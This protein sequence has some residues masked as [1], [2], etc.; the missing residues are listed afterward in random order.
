MFPPLHQWSPQDH[1]LAKRGKAIFAVPTRPLV[2]RNALHRGMTPR[3]HAVLCPFKIVVITCY[4]MLSHV[5]TCYHMLSHVIT[6]YHM[7]SPIDER[8][9]GNLV[10]LYL[11]DLAEHQIKIGK[12]GW[13]ISW[14][15][16]NWGRI[17]AR[18]LAFEW[19]WQWANIEIS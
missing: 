11:S 6:C 14:K 5:I 9:L 8:S 15:L 17:P 4:H 16:E 19:D 7:S 10:K 12:L 3:N 13:S 2:P 1:F 18:S